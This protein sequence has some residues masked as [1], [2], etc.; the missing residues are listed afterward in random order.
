MTFSHHNVYHHVV[1]FSPHVVVTTVV[2]LC[3]YIVLY[4]VSL[5]KRRIEYSEFRSYKCMRWN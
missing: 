1:R 4:Q 2:D 3:R 5:K